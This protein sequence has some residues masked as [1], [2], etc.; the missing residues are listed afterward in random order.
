MKPVSRIN[1]SSGENNCHVTT[2]IRVCLLLLF[3]VVFAG[4]SK[5]P[6][7]VPIRSEHDPDIFP[8]EWLEAP[9]NTKATPIAPEEFE[10]G[11]L[12]VS[13]TL[14]KYPERVL[15]SNLYHIY[16]LGGLSFSGVSAGGTN[17]DTHVY[18]V[19]S[20]ER[21]GYTAESI[22]KTFHHEFSSILFH[23]HRR[24]FRQGEWI[25]ANPPEFRYVGSGVE[26]V[27]RR[28]ASLEYSSELSKLGFYCEY[29]Q[30]TLENDFN[31]IA[32][33]LFFGDQQLWLAYE[34]SD[35]MRKKIDIAISFYNQIN[36]EFD[37]KYFRVIASE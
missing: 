2:R 33:L 13:A 22:E 9:Y 4:C 28:R 23:N 30:S 27:K 21:S 20:D 15:R 35:S 36:S 7:P 19:V 29:S 25:S 24:Y 11:F 1:F 5:S 14:Q 31:V 34:Q 6:T 12:I 3:C 10:R 26:A 37:E 8:M 32:E 18:I 17:S 16:L